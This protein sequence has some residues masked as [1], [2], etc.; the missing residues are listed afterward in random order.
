MQMTIQ[1]SRHAG[2]GAHSW[3]RRQL[4][5]ISWRLQFPGLSKGRGSVSEDVILGAE[6]QLAPG[7]QANR[8]ELWSACVQIETPRLFSSRIVQ[9]G[10][11][12]SRDSWVIGRDQHA[13]R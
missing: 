3:A 10:T 13:L 12:A 7:S 9:S 1:L 8:A 2:A 11:C 4:D 5:S 6:S